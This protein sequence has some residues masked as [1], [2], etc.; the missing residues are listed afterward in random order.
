MSFNWRLLLG[1]AEIL[2]YVVWHE[3]CH[4]V[5]MDHSRR[6]WSLLERHR[7]GYRT[8]R[9]WLRDQRRRRSSCP[10][11][12]RSS[13]DVARGRARRRPRDRGRLRRNGEGTRRLNRRGA[14]TL[15]AP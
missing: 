5:H 4:L 15:R 1:P 11:T 7:P 6:F 9:R 8:P 10:L 3:A 2:D 13:A 12:M 14:H